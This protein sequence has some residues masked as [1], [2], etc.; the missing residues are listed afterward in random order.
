MPRS[1]EHWE[2]RIGKRLRLRD[3]HVLLTVVQ[4]RSMAKAARR[5]AVSQPAVSKAISDLEY[6][7][8]VQL[9]DRGPRGVEPTL[10][11]DALVRRGLVVFDE[12][13]QGVGE[14]EFM[15]NP[16][17]G[18]VRVGC[19]EWVLA[20]LIP[21]VIERLSNQYPGV[22]VHVTQTN[23]ATLD[24]R[25]LRERNIDLLIGRLGRAAEQAD[26]NDQKWILYPPNSEPAAIVESAFHAQ[27]LALPQASVTTH[28]HY[29]RDILLATGQYLAIV[30]I[31]MLGVYN[32]KRVTVKRLQLDLGIKSSPMAI[33]TLRNRTLSPVIELFIECVRATASP[34]WRL[35]GKAPSRAAAAAAIKAAINH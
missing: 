10:Y 32:R 29:L 3:L 16:T 15:A 26:L 1:V 23:P 14:I 22:V 11:G 20:T 7:L 17:V 5:L 34:S 19:F 31:S 25:E 2:T 24:L 9:L 13:R 4:H 27:G 33:F 35:T 30:P 8:G 18:E 28:S 12:L 21:P 6:T